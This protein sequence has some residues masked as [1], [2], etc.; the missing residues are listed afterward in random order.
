MLTLARA[1]IARR[2]IGWI[3]AH[4]SNLLPL[5]RLRETE[6]LLAFHHP[7]PNYPLHILL[8][9]KR[10]IPNLAALTPADADFTADLF[11]V[12]QSLIAQFDLQ[13]HGY[14]LIVNGGPNQHIPQLHFH[15][16]SDLPTRLE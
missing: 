9:P 8:V 10:T 5:K 11:A 3:F 1:A 12:V 2:F 7:Q 4:M 14:R 15:L 6:T 13:Q 16:I